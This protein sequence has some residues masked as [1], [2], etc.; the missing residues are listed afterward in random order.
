MELSKFVKD[1]RATA[2]LTQP[3]LAEK[4]GVGLRFIRDLEQGKETLRLDKVN[5]VLQLFGYQA[6]PVP[7]NRNELIDEKS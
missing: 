4:A 6:G 3:E 5:Q 1:K 2:H 7:L